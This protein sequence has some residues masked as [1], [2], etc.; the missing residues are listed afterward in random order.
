MPEDQRA[1]QPSTTIVPCID[2]WMPQMYANVPGSLNVNE[3]VAPLSRSGDDERAVVRLD[4]VRLAVAVRPGHDRAGLDGQLRRVEGEVT[5]LHGCRPRWRNCRSAR[6]GRR[7]D[8]RPPVVG[9]RR[10]RTDGRHGRHDGDDGGRQNEHAW[11]IHY[12]LA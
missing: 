9:R 11:P 12:R 7:D 3:N 1:T 2:V 4:R 10:R 8:V 6:L 5:D